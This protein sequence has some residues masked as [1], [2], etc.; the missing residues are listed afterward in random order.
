[1][2]T[3]LSYLPNNAVVIAYGAAA[4]VGS[5]AATQQVAP[6]Q[7]P[8]NGC[9]AT[10]CAECS[11]GTLCRLGCIGRLLRSSDPIMRVYRGM[12]LVSDVEHDKRLPLNIPLLRLTKHF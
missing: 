5:A 2:W 9:Q 6:A 7:T 8:W 1:M 4:L 10:I 12:R 11:P 3:D